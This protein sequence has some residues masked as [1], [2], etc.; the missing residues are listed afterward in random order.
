MIVREFDAT[1]NKWVLVSI[2]HIS[3]YGYVSV[4]YY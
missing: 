2:T 3:P 4:T 1:L